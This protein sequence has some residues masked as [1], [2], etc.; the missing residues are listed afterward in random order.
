[1]TVADT[2]IEVDTATAEDIKTVAEEITNAVIDRDLLDVMVAHV[3][4]DSENLVEAEV[5][6]KESADI[7][8]TVEVPHR[9]ICLIFLPTCLSP[10]VLE[11]YHIQT[12]KFEE[13]S[14]R[15]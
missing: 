1:M 11:G 5:D 10:K 2:A 4:I 3:E 7:K 6:N 8:G 9:L 12:S 14:A 13:P 15:K